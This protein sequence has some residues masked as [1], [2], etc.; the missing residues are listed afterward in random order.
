MHETVMSFTPSGKAA[1]API[2]ALTPFSLNHRPLKRHLTILALLAA[3]LLAQA[4]VAGLSTLAV[5]DMPHGARSAGFGFD[6]LSLYDADLTLAMD[7]P[8]LATPQMNSQL[9]LGY[10]NLFGTA[11]YGMAAYCRDYG[12]LGVFTFGIQFASY[13][14]F[15]GYD[16]NDVHTG[17]FTAA[18]YLFTIGWGHRVDDHITVGANCK[19]ILSHYES[20]TAFAIGFDLAATWMSTDKS[21]SATLMGRNI[22]AQLATF[23]GTGE[24]LPYELSLVGSYKL[25]DAPFRLLFALNE[26]QQWDLTYDDP[27]NPTTFVDPFT[28][29][30]TKPTSLA[31]FSDKLFRHFACGIE[32]NIRKSFFARLGYSYRQMIEME[33]ADRFNTSGFSFGFGIKT[34]KFQFA[35]SR[36]NYHITQ[37]PNYISLIFN[38]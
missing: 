10:V 14:K 5:L 16:E 15:E 4:Q 35:Y 22:G 26:L 6:Y 21:F 7:N 38:I 11:N 32:L 30:V 36:N 28:G 18:D 31:T 3:S 29:E 23:D 24:K 20:Y 13:G 37:A 19:P 33:A 25:Q 2:T 34:E 1:K 12:R 9:A 17:D 8:S 27:L